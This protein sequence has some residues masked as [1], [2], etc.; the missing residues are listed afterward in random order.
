MDFFI[1]E[2]TD[3]GAVDSGGSCGVDKVS[4]RLGRF[5]E[6]DEITDDDGTDRLIDLTAVNAMTI[7]SFVCE[8]FA[9]FTE[10]ERADLQVLV[11]N[12]LRRSEEIMLIN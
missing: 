4:G 1:V 6:R 5:E 8:R 9:R 10:H 11:V 7:L 2:D 12:D 3:P